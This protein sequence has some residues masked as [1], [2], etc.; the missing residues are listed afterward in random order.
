MARAKTLLKDDRF[1]LTLDR[2]CYEIIENYPK[3]KQKCIIG[4][5]ERGVHLAKRIVDRLKSLESGT[6]VQSGKLDITFYRDDFRIRNTLL[7][8]SE[9]D[10]DFNLDGADVI[11]VDDVLFSGRTINAAMAAL[12]D[13]GRPAKIELLVMV[14]RRFNRHLPIQANYAG[15]VVDALDE[16]YVKVEFA[17]LPGEDQDRILLKNKPSS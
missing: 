10:I 2:L 7:Q 13:F 14:D 12:Q 6:E 15:L 9:T 5:Q 11:L 4:I 8:A 3:D 17:N 1:R 16:A